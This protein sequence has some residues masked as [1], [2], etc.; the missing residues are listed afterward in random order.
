MD[1]ALA[2]NDFTDGLELEVG[3]NGESL[4]CFPLFLFGEVKVGCGE[5]MGEEG[6]H[7]H[8]ALRKSCPVLFAPVGLLH[9]F[10]QGELKARWSFREH[11][12]FG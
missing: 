1:Q 4:V 12:A 5:A 7:S 9:V 11:H 3:T 10:T 2:L 8:S 6:F